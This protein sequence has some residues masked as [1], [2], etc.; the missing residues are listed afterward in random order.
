MPDD[1][2]KKIRSRLRSYERKLRKEKEK[3]GGY[4]DGAG[5]RYQIGPHYMLLDDNDGALT[6]FQWFE[7]EFPDDIGVPD[8]F[9]CWSLALYRAGNEIGA[10]KKLRQTMFSNLYLVPR[11][12][13]MPIAELDIWHGSSDAE[14]SYVEHI[15]EPYLQ[16]WTDAERE[17]AR[18]LY[19]GPGFRSARERFIEIARALDT[20]RPGPER[21]RLVEEMHK[22]EG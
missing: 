20:T 17:W 3:Y 10:A 9:L 1:E 12:L 16:I 13:G 8:H 7:T 14:P 4:D 5:K 18:A 15:H 11:L 2:K 6:A 21:S 22:L 19:E